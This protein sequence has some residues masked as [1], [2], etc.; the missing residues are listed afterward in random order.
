MLLTNSA[1]WSILGYLPMRVTRVPRVPTPHRFTE[2]AMPR[3]G[4]HG[5][6]GTPRVRAREC[7]GVLAEVASAPKGRFDDL[8]DTVSA[9]LIHLRDRGLLSLEEWGIL[10]DHRSR[11][12]RSRT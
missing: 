11:C 4:L 7:I 9:A 2:R 5:V 12:C 10:T 6:T 1:S 8:C 3:L